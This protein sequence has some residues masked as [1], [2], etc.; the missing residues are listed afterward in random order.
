MKMY[1]IT[2]PSVKRSLLLQ[3]T[4]F[5]LT[6]CIFVLGTC[7]ANDNKEESFLDAQTLV[8]GWETNY[9]HIDSFKVRCSTIPLEEKGQNP[10]PRTRPRFFLYE[11]IQDGG[12]FFSR[13]TRSPQGFD[14][15][16]DYSVNVFDGNIGREYRYVSNRRDRHP[17]YKVNSDGSVSKVYVRG[18]LHGE[19]RAYGTIYRDPHGRDTGRM[20]LLGDFLGSLPATFSSGIRS[21][22]QYPLGVPTFIR[23]YNSALEIDGVLVYPYMETVAGELCHVLEL[24]FENHT[25]TYWFAHD[26]GMILMKTKWILH[27]SRWTSHVRKVRTK[28]AK[29]IVSVTTEKG[30]LWYPRI[31]TDELIRPD[32]SYTT[33]VTVHEFVPY[34]KAPAEKFDYEFPNGTRVYDSIKDVR[35][36][37][38]E[39]KTATK[40]ALPELKSTY[41][42]PVTDEITSL[43][44]EI[45]NV[46]TNSVGMKLRLIKPG[47]FVMG[48]DSG[49]DNEKP[50]HRVT[51]T[52]PF[53]IG[54]C[55]VTQQQYE[56]VMGTNPSSVKGTRRPVDSV[57]WNDAYE[58]CQ[59]LSETENRPYRLP[60]EAEW[61]YACRSGT[62]TKY[63]WSDEADG[64]YAW[65]SHNS[66][67]VAHDVGARLPN[68]WGLYDM[69]GNVSEWCA[70]WYEARYSDGDD[71]SDPKG[72][73]NGQSRVIRGGS[74]CDG[75]WYCH[76]ADRY[77]GE[78]DLCSWYVGFRIVL[79]SKTAGAVHLQIDQIS[80]RA[81]RLY[82]ELDWHDV[83]T[84]SVGMK[85][86]LIKPGSFM[87]R[88]WSEPFQTPVHKT[89]T[90]PFYIGVCEVTQQQYEKVMDANPSRYKGSMLPVDSVSWNDANEFCQRLSETENRPYRLPTEVEWE[91]ACR[92]GTTTDYYWGNKPDDWYAWTRH[93]SSYIVHDVGTRLPNAWGLHDMSGNV[94]EWCA[95]MYVVY[96]RRRTSQ[97]DLK[98]LSNE[99]FRVAR[100]GSCYDVLGYCRSTSRTGGPQVSRLDDQHHVG[101]RIVL[102]SN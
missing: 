37:V 3:Y 9:G 65:T 19:S 81:K 63:Y 59:R 24:D 21:T 27:E 95:D 101:F 49:E 62:T 23:S 50:A 13:R 8:D 90:K 98:R 57:S 61:E 67:K 45:D 87:M 39:S 74:W 40:K 2:I 71:Q 78:P 36:I 7:S 32:Y 88:S 42:G 38:G 68:V 89:L 56:K 51:L 44:Q 96:S 15:T 94:W 86:K 47:S 4:F 43:L 33:K 14:D 72:P 85:V 93:N 66:S 25:H 84:N 79:D 46:L 80:E 16:N 34:F 75:P 30:V 20:N 31:I 41:S 26:K 64:R 70:D 76:S 10:N 17:N 53:F 102:D 22:Q 97:N 1:C 58:F 99:P 28:E 100:G 29:E 12:K 18:V 6:C 82:N 91:Y 52:K 55:E 69:S 48:C 92:A 35:Y 60:T 77:G 11:R 73:S 54:V 83:L 5:A